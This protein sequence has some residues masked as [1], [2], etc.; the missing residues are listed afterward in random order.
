MIPWVGLAQTGSPVVVPDTVPMQARD[1][2]SSRAH[3]QCVCA[4]VPPFRALVPLA[5]TLLD[6]SLPFYYRVAAFEHLTNGT[7]EPSP[8]RARVAKHTHA[9]LRSTPAAGSPPRRRPPR[10]RP[11]RRRRPRRRRSRR[12]RP[13]RRRPLRRRPRPRCRRPRCCRC[14]PCRR[15]PCRPRPHGRFPRRRRRH[16]L[17]CSYSRRPHLTADALAAV[18]LPAASAVSAS[19]AHAPHRQRTTLAAATIATRQP[20]LQLIIDSRSH[21]VVSLKNQ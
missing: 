14:P 10:R 7:R 2:R 15:R 11:P 20:L 19:V 5:G 13:R 17:R 3:T 6:M 21:A 4:R 9:A 18:T 8:A 1:S 12:R 16:H